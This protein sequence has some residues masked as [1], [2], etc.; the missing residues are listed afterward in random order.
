[1]RDSPLLALSLAMAVLPG[2]DAAGA[3]SPPAR[4]VTRDDNAFLGH[5]VDPGA[6][7]GS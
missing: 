4:A 6:R 3:P 2:V 1:M 7:P 5:P